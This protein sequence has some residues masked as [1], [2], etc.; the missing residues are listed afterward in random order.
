ME[1]DTS[2]EFLV[3]CINRCSDSTA[4]RDGGVGESGTPRQT[5]YHIMAIPMTG[6]IYLHTKD[7]F[8]AAASLAILN[9]LA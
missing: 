9:V 2:V 5:S 6:L 3:T 4:G 1:I 8:S 7:M